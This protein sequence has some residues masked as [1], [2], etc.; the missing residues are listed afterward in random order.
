MIGRKPN[1]SGALPDPPLPSATDALLCGG[2]ACS[3]KEAIAVGQ[4]IRYAHLVQ[5]KPLGECRCGVRKAD[6]RPRVVS[7]SLILVFS[8]RSRFA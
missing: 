1:D 3:A 8:K 6:E 5:D 2:V 4:T 7:I